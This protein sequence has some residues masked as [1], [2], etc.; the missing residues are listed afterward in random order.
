M[1]DVRCVCGKLLL[2]V[3]GRGMLETKCPRCKK[4]LSVMYDGGNIAVTDL[5]DIREAKEMI[6]ATD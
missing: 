5:G 2:K 3:D 4:Y 6:G 1:T